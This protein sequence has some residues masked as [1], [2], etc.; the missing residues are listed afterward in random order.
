MTDLLFNTPWWLPTII[1][2][3]GAMMLFSGNNRGQDKL[4]NV[5]AGVILIALLLALVSYFVDTDKEKVLGRTS[6]LVDSIEKQDWP[7][8]EN[9][10]DAQTSFAGYTGK[11]ELVKLAK[12]SSAK[13]NIKKA[14]IVSKQ[15]VQTDTLITVT[16]DAVT[17]QDLPPGPM[18]SQWETD[19][20]Q[21]GDQWLLYKI[22]P[23]AIAG[24][25][26]GTV[27]GHLPSIK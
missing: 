12:A 18:R 3:A 4:R 23:L 20:Q 8:F 26:W 1:A 10:L 11:A 2:V 6:A 15:A 9:L 16:L 24:Q 17:E 5:G 19:W 13:F 7:T 22:T 21:R 25:P 14:Y 27:S